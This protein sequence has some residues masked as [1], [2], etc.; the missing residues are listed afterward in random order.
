MKNQKVLAWGLLLLFPL[1]LT[2]CAGEGI[3]EAEAETA[4]RALLEGEPATANPFF[5]PAQRQDEEN[6]SLL[7]SG[8]TLDSVSCDKGGLSRMD[9]ALAFSDEAGTSDT[10]NIRFTLEDGLLCRAEFLP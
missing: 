5:C 9:C 10:L 8:Q 7:S 4:I 2:A 6:P 1:L 3:S